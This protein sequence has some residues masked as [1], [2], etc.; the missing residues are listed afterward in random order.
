M[1]T[2]FGLL[3]DFDLMNTV[4]SKSRKQEGVFS[5]CGRH[6]EKWIWRHIFAVSAVISTKFG[7]L[8][9]NKMQI[10]ANSRGRKCK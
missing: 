10:T 1:S 5:P 9:Q 8:M 4:A 2:K 3:I 6:L 7:S